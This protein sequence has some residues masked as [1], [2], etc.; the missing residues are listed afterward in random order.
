MMLIHDIDTIRYRIDSMYRQ[1]KMLNKFQYNLEISTILQVSNWFVSPNSHSI[2]H[3]LNL[4]HLLLV[5]QNNGGSNALKV[6]AKYY[7]VSEIIKFY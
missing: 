6:L 5:D 1:M 4:L 2:N 3:L 7:S